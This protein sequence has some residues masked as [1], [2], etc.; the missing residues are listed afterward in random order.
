MSPRQLLLLCLAIPGLALSLPVLASSSRTPLSATHRIFSNTATPY[1]YTASS[2]YDCGPLR[3]TWLWEVEHTHPDPLPRF[4]FNWAG[5]SLNGSLPGFEQWTATRWDV[6]GLQP[7]PMA[8]PGKMTFQGLAGLTTTF[9]PEYY[10]HP[11]SVTPQKVVGIV[12]RLNN[13]GDSLFEMS[14]RSS[15][16]SAPPQNAVVGTPMAASAAEPGIEFVSM[17]ELIGVAEYRYTYEVINRLDTPIAFTWDALGLSDVD[18]AAMDTFM[19]ALESSL[20]PFETYGYIES[21]I[22]GDPL[23]G[24]SG[25]AT[26]I[27]G[28]AAVPIPGAGWLLTGALGVLVARR[29]RP[30]S[31][32]DQVRSLI[33]RQNA[34]DIAGIYRLDSK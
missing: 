29:R 32:S 10:D 22:D 6:L 21:W 31:G 30:S 5:I 3:C 13:I 15:G 1:L 16:S 12:D 2:S 14:G 17:V 9:S 4:T 25:P 18:V 33:Y 28:L 34:A 7:N 19:L 23:S 27:V 11:A 20:A 8:T 24:L 26:T